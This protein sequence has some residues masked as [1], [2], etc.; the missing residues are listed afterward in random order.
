MPPPAR[1]PLARLPPC[2]TT[3]L[4][5][6]PR[7]VAACCATLSSLASFSAR[8]CRRRHERLIGR[9]AAAWSTA[10]AARLT[11]GRAA[12]ALHACFGAGGGAS[13][14]R[15]AQIV[16]E[17][18]GLRDKLALEPLQSAAEVG[19]KRRDRALQPQRLVLL[20][21][22]ERLRRSL[23]GDEKLGRVE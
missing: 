23:R 7:S 5:R 18:F 13:A 8:T 17:Q 10:A 19:A 1:L 16:G 4:S 12:L 11:L 3:R 20:A 15:R 6:D 2:A 22:T 21:L 14:H 9:E